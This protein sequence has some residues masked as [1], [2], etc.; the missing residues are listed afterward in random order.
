MEWVKES[1]LKSTDF[2]QNVKTYK[3]K[4]VVFSTKLGPK[5]EE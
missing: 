3:E 4:R 5:T 1:T 2:Q